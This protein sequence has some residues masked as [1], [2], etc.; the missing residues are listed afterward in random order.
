MRENAATLNE[1]KEYLDIFD[2]ADM[3]EEGMA[4]LSQLAL[5]DNFVTTIAGFFTEHRPA[6]RLKTSLML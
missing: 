6:L 1:M 2:K 5:P 3:S 4:Y